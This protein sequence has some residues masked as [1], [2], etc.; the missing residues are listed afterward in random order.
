MKSLRSPTFRNLNPRVAV[1]VA[2]YLEVPGEFVPDSP[3][4]LKN[5]DDFR[6][7]NPNAPV[8]ALIEEYWTFWETDAIDTD[9][10]GRGSLGYAIVRESVLLHHHGNAGLCPDRRLRSAYRGCLRGSPALTVRRT[11]TG[12]QGL[13]HRCAY[14]RPDHVAACR[15]DCLAFNRRL[16]FVFLRR[17]RA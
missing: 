2:R 8:P 15:R 7:I 16:G 11:A 12:M 9:S 6:R 3:R 5:Q 10:K 17:L 13:E 4:H 14:C 1:A